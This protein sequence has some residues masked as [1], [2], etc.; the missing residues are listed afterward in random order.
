MPV[1]YKAWQNFGQEPSNSNDLDSALKLLTIFKTHVMKSRSY[2]M[3]EPTQ[4]LLVAAEL[5]DRALVMYYEG[6]SYFA[7]LH[8]AGG[9]EEILG[10]YAERLGYESSFRSVQ[11]GAVR[12][13]KFLN[14][15]IETKPKNI[16]DIMNYARNRTKHMDKKDDD[17]V[18][19][20]PQTE[21]CSLLSR[22]VSNYYA[23]MNHYCFL[24]TEL[25]ARFNAELAG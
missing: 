9:A 19:F 17:H 3:L 18:Q 8:L 16:A 20:D 10:A 12:L 11:D 15:G 2:V 21:A 7:A 5:L 14:G 6:N 13:S 22:A 23:V 24:E 25:V 4:K 1:T